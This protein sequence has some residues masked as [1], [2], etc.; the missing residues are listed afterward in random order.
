MKFKLILLITVLLLLSLSTAYAGN[1][2]RSGTAGA[3]ELL[4]PY[5]S[6]GTAMG[7]A[8]LSTVSGLESMY[9]NPAGLA[10]MESTEVMFSYMPY[11]ADIDVNF[12]G[13]ATNVEGFGT[14]G[15]GA[16]VISIGDIEETTDELPDGSGR[17][18]S[19]TLLVLNATYSKVMTANV[20]FGLTAMYISESIF[21]VSASGL[22]FDVGFIYDPRWNGVS[23]GIT[24]KNYGA[25]ME[26]TGDG[27]DQEVGQRPFSPSGAKFDLPSSINVGM[28]YDFMNEGL[29]F[30]SFSG[31]FQSNNY[32]QD[33]FHGGAEYVYDSKYSLRGGYS[34]SEQ[35]EYI[36]GLSFGAGLSLPIGED[37]MLRFDYTWMETDV[38]ALDANQYFTL[39]ASF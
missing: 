15:F 19:P 25:E 20:S 13:I 34:Y 31:T 17:F 2:T 11:L 36:Y 6:R 4:I 35:D 22:A 21:E 3:S 29:N 28:A 12:F 5:G 30:A 39:T 10:S 32:S 7:G 33:I 24:I 16:K 1:E 18:F 37:A 27:F 38:D 23:M 26:F 9:W 14:I 8:V